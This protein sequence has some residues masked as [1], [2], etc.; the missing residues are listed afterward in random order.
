V[1]EYSS[2]EEAREELLDADLASRMDLADAQVLKM[3]E[4]PEDPVLGHREGGA[5][6][7]GGGQV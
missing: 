2:V 4:V 7:V 6:E 1:V 3:V 5:Q